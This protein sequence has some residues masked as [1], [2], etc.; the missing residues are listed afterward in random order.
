[1]AKIRITP[2]AKAQLIDIWNYTADTWGEAKADNFLMEID[3]H[4]KTLATNPFLGKNRPE[5]KRV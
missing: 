5:I 4:F 1:M 2:A 3:T